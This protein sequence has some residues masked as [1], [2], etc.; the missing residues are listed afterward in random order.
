MGQVMSVA[1][2]SSGLRAG[3]STASSLARVGNEADV[4]HSSWHSVQSLVVGLNAASLLS[5]VARV[6]GCA[7]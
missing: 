4:A 2:T 3:D 6:V 5:S 1:T 7:R